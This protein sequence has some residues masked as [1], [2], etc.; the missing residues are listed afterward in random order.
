M[1][2]WMDIVRG[3]FARAA[4]ERPD[5][6]VVEELAGFLADAYED[7]CAAGVSAEEAR[8]RALRALDE[9]ALLRE[10]LA[11]RQPPVRARVAHWARREEGPGTS[12]LSLASLAGDAR[13]ALRLVLRAPVFSAIAI[14]TFAIG[15]G[16]NAAVFTVVNGVLLRP[17][18]YA[19]ADRIA[20]IWLDN[21]RQGIR[22]DI[23]SYPIYVDWR[24][25]STSFAEMA[26]YAPASFTLIGAGEPDRLRGAQAT[27]SFFGVLGV[28]PVIGRVFTDREEA[29]GQDGVVVLSHGLW[30]RR[31]GGTPDVVGRTL[32]L[33]GRPREVVGV[34]GPALRWPERAEL[35]VPLAPP[36]DVRDARTSFW[37]P[38]IGRVTH[39]VSTDRAQV[40][41]SA[42]AAALEEEYP[43][44]RGFGAAVVPL[45]EQLVGDVRRPLLV[46]LV[47]V[48]FVLLIACAN[49]ANLTL[50][51]TAA[52]QKELAVRAAIGA[53]RGR[54]IRQ[55]LTETLVLALVGAACGVLLAKAAT[56]AFVGLA[57]GSLPRPDAIVMD[58][59]V[60][61]FALVVAAGSALL[62][63]LV[64][65]LQ[66]SRGALAE[67]LREGGR[68]GGGGTGRR[69][70][71]SLVAVQVA[72]AFVLLTGAGLLVRSLWTMQHV[73]RGFD[74]DRVASM[75]LSLPPARFSQPGD[76][77]GLYARLLERV[78]ALPGVTS[79]A[80]TT[81]VLQPVVA[82]SAV[83]EVEGR[84]LPPPEERVE[85]PYEI[86]SP[87]F[88]ETLRVTLVAGRPF[89]DADHADAP[90]AV[91]INESLARLAWPDQ[92]HAV[93][94]RLRQP[95]DDE[96]PWMTVVG[97]IRDVRRADVRRAVR[98][99]LY[100]S[101]LQVTPRTQTLLVRTAGDPLAIVPAVRRELHA[102]DPG[103]PLFDVGTL[104][105]EMA[106]TLQDSRF[107]ATLLAG[108]AGIALLLAA[109]G[110][111]GVTSHAVSQRVHEVGIRMA[112][113]ARAADV[114]GL[115]LRQH[116]RPAAIGVLVGVAGA[117]AVTQYLRALLYGVGPADP[118]TFVT[119]GLVL[120]AVA[121]AA[122]WVP[123]RR[124]TQ[125]DPLQA[126][127]TE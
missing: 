82:N 109:V 106:G 55:I 22:E 3:R 17:L 1:Q 49:L 76:V 74:V 25:R 85:Y 68:E 33:N 122:C 36:P 2:H 62:A 30:Q 46:L 115:I 57:G 12:R 83:F 101:A 18:P 123:A 11:A 98:P 120:G 10:A 20:M 16:A 95:G 81:G 5:E 39:G 90:R 127:R 100:F 8:A 96:T 6:Q 48:G 43:E 70:S 97:V 59:R 102:L 107:Q 126:L 7:A 38:V 113:G 105:A 24:E 65:A 84:P 41:M 63:G 110:V 114:L 71:A 112:L 53:G 23:A 111:Y 66:A 14:L 103:L 37:L 58:G 69:T 91:V 61:G 50:G 124:A 92:Q 28:E 21:R 60:L 15:I 54:I 93:G 19:D 40:E 73:D 86:V 56:A 27:A 88:F 32:T 42:I 119:V 89:T 79:A 78:R 45:H 75:T 29:V 99:E 52:R 125:V 9:S 26:A 4:G 77:R 94:R 117:L 51:R 47:A 80:T 108:L 87:G 13:H 104:E 31:F 118:L 64:P 34:M 44:L 35:W 121:V 72:L 67:A 116:L